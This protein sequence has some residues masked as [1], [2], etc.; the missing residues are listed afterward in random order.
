MDL[1]PGLI[2]A[3]DSMRDLEEIALVAG[4]R[5]VLLRADADEPGVIE[6]FRRQRDDATGPDADDDARPGTRWTRDRI[7]TDGDRLV[8]AAEALGHVVLAFEDA[9]PSESGDGGAGG[10]GDEAVMP[11]GPIRITYLRPGRSEM[12]PVA[13]LEGLGRFV[14]LLPHRGAL[15]ILHRPPGDERV[16]IYDLDFSE[17]TMRSDEPLVLTTPIRRDDLSP[18]LLISA[19]VLVT[20]VA[21]LFPPDPSGMSVR[22]PPATALAS[23]VRRLLAVMIDL[24]PSGA[25]TML[26]MNVSARE[27]VQMPLGP[28]EMDELAPKLVV[29]LLTVLHSAIA[30]ALTGRTLGKWLMSSRVVSTDG[31]RAGLSQ[32]AVRNAMKFVVLIVP[33][34]ALIVF[35]SPFR[36]RVGDRAARTLVVVDLPPGTTT[37]TAVPGSGDAGR[38][39][40]DPDARRR[41]DDDRDAR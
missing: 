16:H 32:V 20:L 31:T 40:E 14:D 17:G 4:E 34:L 18:F 28:M 30:E 11:E 15:G 23:P 39:N 6:V 8:G 19:L 21:V 36:Q 12:H 33:P 35:F 9:A 29:Y 5:L 27:I 38:G 37:G 41:E 13:T 1:P 26:V 2:D 10:A 25:I 3:D 22:L 24:A 7:D